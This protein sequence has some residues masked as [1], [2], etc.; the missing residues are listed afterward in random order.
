MLKRWLHILT[1]LV[2]PRL[3]HGLGISSC[4]VGWCVASA[5]ILRTTL[6]RAANYGSVPGSRTAIPRDELMLAPPYL[7]L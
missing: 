3:V 1:S 7:A 6:E 5:K 2:A 4:G